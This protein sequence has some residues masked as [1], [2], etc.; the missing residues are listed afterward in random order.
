M[1]LCLPWQ[2]AHE[3]FRTQFAETW[4]FQ[5]ADLASP[6]AKLEQVIHHIST[7]ATYAHHHDIAAEH[8]CPRAWAGMQKRDFTLEA[9][10][11]ALETIAQPANVKQLSS[12]GCFICQLHTALTGS[13]AGLGSPRTMEDLQYIGGGVAISN[14][15]L[16]EDIPAS[17]APGTKLPPPIVRGDRFCRLQK[18]ATYNCD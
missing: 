2:E 9:P 14:H 10:L 11:R 7:L 12:G 15:R 18:G 8:E 6:R 3:E 17:P 4:G 13:R 16:E 5:L 1:G